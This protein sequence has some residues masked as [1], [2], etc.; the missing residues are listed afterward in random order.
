MRDQRHAWLAVAPPVPTVH[1]AVATQ[2]AR[3]AFAPLTG[4]SFAARARSRARIRRFIHRSNGRPLFLTDRQ[5][6]RRDGS[7]C[8]GRTMS[9]FKKVVASLAIF[10]AL[11]AMF[12]MFAFA[13]PRDPTKVVPGI[14]CS[15][16]SENDI[17]AVLGA[18]MRLMPTSGS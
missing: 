12:A 14:P 15:V 13:P 5:V 8:D 1:N 9:E 10:V 18:Q 11:F 4:T 7:W 16:L 17:G 3:D 6:R 2:P